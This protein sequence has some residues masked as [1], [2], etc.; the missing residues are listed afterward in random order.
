MEAERRRA[1]SLARASGVDDSTSICSAPM[2][3]IS[4]VCRASPP[5]TNRRCAASAGNWPNVGSTATHRPQ[6]DLRPR[7]VVEFPVHVGQPGRRPGRNARRPR[8]RDGRA[9]CARCSRRS[10]C[11]APR[12]ASGMPNV[13]RLLERVVHPAVDALGHH[14]RVARACRGGAPPARESRDCA[15]RTSGSGSSACNTSG[16]RGTPMKNRGARLSRGSR[17]TVSVSPRSDLASPSRS[18][19]PRS[20]WRSTTRNRASCRVTWR[21]AAIAVVSRM[22]S[23]AAA[24]PR[25]APSP[26]M[27]Q[28][29]YATSYGRRSRRSPICVVATMRP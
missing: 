16:G 29:S 27:R 17:V 19:P 10:A 23:L 26:L 13:I 3:E 12:A 22:S 9:A 1:R 7:V 25:G 6:I 5:T 21:F 11:A 2:S 28:F 4:A 20:A 24:P 8:Q 14:A 15:I 18:K